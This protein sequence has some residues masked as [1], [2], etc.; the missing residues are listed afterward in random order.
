MGEASFPDRKGKRKSSLLPPNQ[1]I[2]DLSLCTS[3]VH[4]ALVGGDAAFK[5]E[6]WFSH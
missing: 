4:P 6:T 1:H 3:G 2:L 5:L